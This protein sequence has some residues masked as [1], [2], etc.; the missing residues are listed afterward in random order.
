MTATAVASCP[1]IPDEVFC[2]WSGYK[3]ELNCCFFAFFGV[4]SGD[5]G[6]LY[7]RSMPD[8]LLL[9]NYFLSVGQWAPFSSVS[10]WLKPLVTSLHLIKA[11]LYC[12]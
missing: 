1:C 10:P 8:L 11:R 6:F 2:A 7:C 3:N 12:R 9:L 5:F 4:F